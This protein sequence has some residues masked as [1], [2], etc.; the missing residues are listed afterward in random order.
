MSAVW[1]RMMLGVAGAVALYGV[2]LVTAGLWLGDHVF[3]RLGFGPAA[4]GVTSAP[5]R[6]YLRLVYGILGAV[7]TG[8]MLT[9]IAVVARP[10]RRGER[11]AWWAVA[12][13]AA[14]WFVLDTGLS[15][16]QEH[17]GHAVFNLVFAVLLGVPLAGMR[18]GAA[19]PPHSGGGPPATP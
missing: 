11:W 16:V 19:A 3:E 4:G 9:L 7:L 6:E 5:A 15:L 17:G 8:W 10:L 2:G 18:R 1:N 14:V 12:G 13:P